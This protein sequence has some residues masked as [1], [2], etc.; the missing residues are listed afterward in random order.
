MKYIVILFIAFN[1]YSTDNFYYNFGNKI[2]LIESNQFIGVKTKYKLSVK[3]IKNKLKAIKDIPKIE[4]LK[5][6]GSNLFLFK[7]SSKI[8]NIENIFKKTSFV[9]YQ[10][11]G[12]H[13]K[14]NNSWPRFIDKQIVIKFKNDTSVSRINE[15]LKENSLY[16]KNTKN[17]DYSIFLVVKSNQ[18]IKNILTLANKLQNLPEVEFSHPDFITIYKKYYTPND[19]YF[20]NQWHHRTGTGGANSNLA[21]DI[22]KGSKSIKIAIIDDGIDSE[23]E[24]LNV[25]AHKNFSTEA[26][27]LGAE[28]GTSCAGVASAIGDNGKGMIGICPNCSLISAKLLS[29]SGAV[30]SSST[31]QAFR[32]AMLMGADVIS[33][34]WGASEAV[35]VSEELK[36]TINYVTANGRNKKGC[37]VLFAVGND[38]RQL[39][40]YETSSL[41]NVIAVGASDYQDKRAEYSNF[42]NYL[43]V[44]A[45]SS[46]GTYESFHTPEGNIWTTDRTGRLGYNNNGTNKDY[47]VRE[48]DSAG[49]YTKYF[50]GTSSA[51]PL[52]AGM[53]GLILSEAPNLTYLEVI[54]IIKT[55]ANKIGNNYNTNGYSVDFGYGKVDVYK[56]LLKAQN[57]S[58]CIPNHDGE[59]C[60]NNQD[61]DCDGFI[62]TND[63][64]CNNYEP[65]SQYSCPEHSKCVFNDSFNPDNKTSINISCECDLGYKKQN[66]SCILDPEYNPCKD[67]KCSNH[68][69]CEVVS[70]TEVKCNCNIGYHNEGETGM[71]CRIDDA[72]TSIKCQENAYCDTND[73]LCHCNR[74]FYNENDKCLKYDQGSLCENAMCSENAKC[75][76]TDGECYC[77]DGYEFGIGN[78]CIKKINTEPKPK[79]KSKNNSSCSY[80]S[81]NNYNYYLS[82]MLFIFLLI[83]RRKNNY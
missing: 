28:H 61:D 27:N 26:E 59:L 20:S 32:W 60:N 18:D 66:G 56:A 6:I 51:T 42:G 67:I 38:N 54:D 7:F 43:T 55:T 39:F 64:D 22:N 48:V 29:E 24:D 40:S 83:F 69:I 12:Y 82:L 79:P 8:D 47:Y 49:N 25:I 16:T 3:E 71:I 35:P 45:P 36:N 33:N 77:N 17:I 9:S 11:K 81:I 52:V 57:L 15:I 50:G 23:H 13:F 46:A 21:W 78:K 10:I 73:V 44:V 72:C 37:I 80:S 53:V 31:P 4:E 14:N 2:P 63:A 41:I 58:N 1:I 70:I 76:N 68:G 74:G 30:Y 34:S 75:N 65:C 5:N 62:D 19:T